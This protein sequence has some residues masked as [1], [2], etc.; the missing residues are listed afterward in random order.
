MEGDKENVWDGFNDAVSNTYNASHQAPSNN[1]ATNNNA[2]GNGA[3]Q[4]IENE[5]GVD[6]L[7]YSKQQPENQLRNEDLLRQLQALN[8]K[9]TIKIQV[10]E[11]ASENLTSRNIQTESKVST[12]ST[13]KNFRSQSPTTLKTSDALNATSRASSQR[14]PISPPRSPP[15]S[16]RSS[17]KRSSTPIIPLSPAQKSTRRSYSP[18]LNSKR[19]RSPRK[20]SSRHKSRS[21][22]P[23]R[24]SSRERRRRSR[25]SERRR[26]SKSRERRSK[27]KSGRK[28]SSKEKG[29]RPSRE[30]ETSKVFIFVSLNICIFLY[31]GLFRTYFTQ[32]LSIFRVR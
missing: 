14:K 12:V 16:S 21:R 17:T 2:I 1:G 22:S 11:F 10:A 20:R 32:S 25:E 26:S 9:P 7:E 15:R 19:S 29:S 3:N 30:R 24:Y 27:S 8:Y 6:P 28:S 13:S 23:R 31:L 4:H 5:D 18:T